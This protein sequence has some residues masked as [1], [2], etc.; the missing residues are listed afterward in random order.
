VLSVEQRT[1][2]LEGKL[3]DMETAS[4][5]AKQ[6]ISKADQDAASL[7]NDFASEVAQ[8][9]QQVESDLTAVNLKMG[10]YHDLMAEAAQNDPLAGRDPSEAL[11]ISYS[12]VREADGKTTEMP[13]EENTAVLP[14]DVVKVR[15]SLPTS[16]LN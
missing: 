4:L 3:L 8:T 1:A 15:V 6:D 12:I 5:Q 16:K 14:G 9:R 7:R 10:M 2:D 11:Q 13:A